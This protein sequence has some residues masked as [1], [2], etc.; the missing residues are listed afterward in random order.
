M[1]DQNTLHSYCFST[2][3]KSVASILHTLWLHLL[4]FYTY[5]HHKYIANYFVSH[6]LGKPLKKHFYYFLVGAFYQFDLLLL[7]WF[8]NI[9]DNKFLC[10][11]YR[12]INKKNSPFWG[13]RPQSDKY[14]ILTLP[15]ILNLLYDNINIYECVLRLT[16]PLQDHHYL[17]HCHLREATH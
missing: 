15:L 16:K 5:I 9:I 7:K 6:P 12:K 2:F 11:H 14:H 1:S 3:F 8:L 13:F 17:F 4:D 10:L